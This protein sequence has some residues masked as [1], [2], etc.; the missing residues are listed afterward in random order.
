MKQ[1]NWCIPLLFSLILP[2]CTQEKPVQHT[3]VIKTAFDAPPAWAKEA[4]WY[5]IFV[6]RFYNGDP[7]ND[8]T[9]IDIE[10]AYPFVTPANWSIT[11]WT[12]DWYK[13]DPY[14]E[15]LKTLSNRFGDTFTEFDQMVQ[16]RRYGGDLQGVLDK[17]DY[18]QELGVT[19]IYF[20][21][22]NDAPSNH[23][24]DPRYWH[25]I[26][27]NFGPNPTADRILLAAENPAD[28][29][30]WQFSSADSLFLQLVQEL[31]QRNM[32]VI[33]D[34]SWNH[35]GMDFW[36]LQD[37]RKNG[38]QSPFVNWYWIDTFDDPNTAEDEFVYQGWFNLPSLPEVKETARHQNHKVVKAYEGNLASESAKEHIFAVT[39]RWLDPNNDGDPTDGVDGFR[40]DVAGELPL[41]FWR[42]FR[43]VVRQVNPDAYLVGEIWWKEWPDDLLDPA[44]FLEG[45]V[46]DAVMNY[47]WYRA[48]RHYFNES[49]NPITVSEFVDSLNS[50]RQNLSLAH[51]YALMNLTAS[52]DVPRVGTSL[53]NKNKYKVETK[54]KGENGY[55]IH[56]P[57]QATYD[58]LRLLLI[59]QF[60]YIGAPHIWAGDEMGMW[61]ADDPSCRKPLI[62]PEFQFETEVAHPLGQDRP[63]DQVAFKQEVFNMYQKLIQ[64][65]KRYA[66]LSSGTT[67]GKR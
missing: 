13:P 41:G 37:I 2:S 54:P 60:T 64:L 12:Q 48:A 30:S 62:W 31:H 55:K 19:A 63:A 21:P 10:N 50:F 57:D 1:L 47:R 17:L 58:I 6:E 29:A 53:F 34:F 44:P 46:F 4:I 18:L 15:T 51:N 33:M 11:P 43:E 65:R 28:P 39:R 56:Q 52:H 16:L 61:G 59:Q 27:R 22:L 26:D 25:H 45:D 66:V 14:F 67:I 42:E 40:L 3:P 32:R 24:Y 23:K 9:V 5:Q 38:S 35:T 36:A 20:N 49:P 7:S 8:P